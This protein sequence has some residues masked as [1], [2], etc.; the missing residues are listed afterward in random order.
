M[1]L[2]LVSHS[3]PLPAHDGGRIGFFN[4]VKYL[5]RTHQVGVVCLAEH[6]E[7]APVA[8]LERHC[9]FVRVFRR[10]PGGDS[11]RL[12]RGIVLDPPGALAKY[13]YPAAGQLIRDAVRAFRPDIVE[14]HHLHT[15]IYQQF[16]QGVLTV[17]RE[18][19]VEY[20]VWERYAGN[21][22]GWVEKR[23]TKWTTPRM[24]RYEAEAALRFDRCVVVSPADAEW[25][26]AVAPAARIEVIPSGV[27]T[28]Y[29]F[30]FVGMPEEAFSMTITGSFAW[31]P[32][33]QSLWSLL[34]KV[35]PKIKAKVPEATLYVVGKG[36]PEEL[37][38]LGATIPGVKI[39]GPLL[40]VRPYIARSALLIN[41]LESGGGIAL[42]VLEAMAMRKP[43]LSN[44]LGCEGIPM[45]HGQDLC[46]ADGPEVFATAAAR[47]LR[48]ESERRRLAASGYQRVLQEYSWHVIAGRL[49]SVYET[50]L[51]TR[52]ALWAARQSAQSGLEKK[53]GHAAD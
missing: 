50:L 31:G 53:D 43:V 13:S 49:E 20:K 33:Q 37:Q 10:K 47:L 16:S 3:F 39:T 42:K 25:L 18:H 27:D 12:I 1:R 9:S 35:F 51:E 4:S 6:S 15:A 23:Y 40:D 44:S 14:F 5:A 22:S 19:N 34:T 8:E 29:F 28:E 32:K 41:Y 24:R 2:L 26:R 17:L 21:A 36:M 46:V 7:E 11:L 30:P 45:T 38:R 48:D 52:R